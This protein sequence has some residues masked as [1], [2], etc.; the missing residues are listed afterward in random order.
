MSARREPPRL[1]LRKARGNRQAHWVILDTVNGRRHEESTGCGESDIV[2]AGVAL[3]KYLAR[4]HLTTAIKDKKDP[5][6]IPVAD[7]LALYARDVAPNHARP[8]ETKQRIDALLDGFGDKVLSDINGEACREYAEKCSTMAAARRQL[9]E[10]RAAINHHRQEGHC[11]KIVGVWLPE[12]P[13][14]RERWLTRAE[15]AAIVRSAWYYREIQ[16]EKQTERRS[17]RHVAKFTLVGLYTGSR[18]GRICG[19]SFY[20]APGFGYIDTDA[21][22][23]YRKPPGEKVTNKRAPPVPLPPRLL[24]HLKRWKENG[25]R[26]VVEWD[27]RPVKTVRKA[28]GNVVS[29]LKLKDVTPH[30][31]R[32]TSA[33]W[34]MQAGVEPWVAAGY[35]GMTVKTLVDNY[36]H[37]HPDHLAEA[38]NAFSRMKAARGAK[39]Q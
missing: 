36:G 14:P 27:K 32:H 5:T 13:L 3:D 39:S 16:K 2:G 9:E 11:S 12:K 18:A 31:L 10:L 17:R 30:T 23:F 1:R 33:T 37:H 7:V 38:K 24:A 19:A 6:A 4:K 29:G 25:Q 8:K 21:G 15:A 34:L 35:L 26:F 22:L 20:P 28:F